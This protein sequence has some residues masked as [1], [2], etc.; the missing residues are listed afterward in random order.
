[1]AKQN[2]W[3]AK[4]CGRQPGGN[5]TGELGVCPAAALNKADGIH[6]G[7]K[8][9]RCCWA[10]AGTFCGGKVQGT[11]AM[12]AGQC[13]NCEFYKQVVKEE[14]ANIIKASDI[15]IKLIK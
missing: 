13:L 2:C 14:G 12:K 10:I 11:F 9:G 6:G 8:G 4:K 7:K 5:K 15:L 3:E 1:M